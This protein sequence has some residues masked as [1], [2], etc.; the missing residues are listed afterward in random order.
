MYL[1]IPFSIPIIGPFLTKAAIAAGT[2]GGLII[3]PSVLKASSNAVALVKDGKVGLDVQKIIRK[4][5]DCDEKIGTIIIEEDLKF[6]NEM[7][8]R[9]IKKIKENLKKLKEKEKKL[10]LLMGK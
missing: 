5:N 10:K 1:I 7:L 4:I 8:M 9:E 2:V 3:A 6:D